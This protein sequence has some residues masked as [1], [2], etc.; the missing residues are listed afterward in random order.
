LRWEDVDIEGRL[1]LGTKRQGE[2]WGLVFTSTIETPLD[3]RKLTDRYKA[4]LGRAD[5][6]DSVP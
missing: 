2:D 1:A 5:P 3:P 4:L 6:Q